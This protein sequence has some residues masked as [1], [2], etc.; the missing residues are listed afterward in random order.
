MP[1]KKTNTYPKGRY[2]S[3]TN[4][5]KAYQGLKQRSFRLHQKIRAN[6]D[7]LESGRT[8]GGNVLSNTNREKLLKSTNAMRASKRRIDKTISA[9]SKV[10]Y[11]DQAYDAKLKRKG[12]PGKYPMKAVVKDR[13][14]T[15]YHNYL[16]S[17]KK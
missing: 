5:Q 10:I 3:Y 11:H 9:M 1:R 4:T 14:M 17:F 16:N 2:K 13:N 6:S 7:K 8:Q 15:N 12:A